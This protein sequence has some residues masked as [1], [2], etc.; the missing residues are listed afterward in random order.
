MKVRAFL[1][2]ANNLSEIEEEWHPAYFINQKG[3]IKEFKG[4]K[5]ELA[6]EIFNE[7]E[8]EIIHCSM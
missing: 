3:D 4:T 5:M 2:V 1:M 6:R 7:I 8:E